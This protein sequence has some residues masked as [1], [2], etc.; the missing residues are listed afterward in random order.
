MII[1]GQNKIS[2]SSSLSSSSP[3]YSKIFLDYHSLTLSLSR[4]DSNLDCNQALHRVE[5]YKSLLVSQRLCVCALELTRKLHCWPP[6]DFHSTIQ[7]DLFI[8]LEWLVKLE[9]SGRTASL[10]SYFH[11]RWQA[12]E[13]SWSFHITQ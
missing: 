9:T 1:N 4:N 3:T 7:H 10:L 12:S 5:V 2:S 6:P 13:I 11:C 8:L